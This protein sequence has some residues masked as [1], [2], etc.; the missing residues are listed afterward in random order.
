MDE[1][2]LLTRHTL[3]ESKRDIH[4]LLAEDEFI[5]RTPAVA[6][7][8]EEGWQVT[9]V[10]NGS[11]AV[12]AL[13]ADNFDLVLM[14]IQMPDMDGIKATAL[15]RENEKGTGEHV[16]I[17]AMTAHAMKGDRER[18]PDG[19]MDGY[20]PKPI[21]I[22]KMLEEINRV[23]EADCRERPLPGFQEEEIKEPLDYDCFVLKRC[24]GKEETAKKMIELLLRE[25]SPRWLAEAEAAVEAQ[26]PDRIRNVCHAI[27]GT[28]S[29]V[30]AQELSDTAVELGRL[31]REGKMDQ[32]L[33]A[34]Q[35]FKEAYVRLQ[36]WGKNITLDK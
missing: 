18:C 29:T 4:I 12:Q 11:E 5:N 32:T 33:Q 7:L 13:A 17:I 24:Q 19:G 6:V 31:A 10:N 16:P 14:D 3:R 36:D 28:A 34:L 26:D 30:C 35:S 15:I 1:Q 22:N 27:I 8:E 2:P 25:T 21:D 9:S 20:I 23:L